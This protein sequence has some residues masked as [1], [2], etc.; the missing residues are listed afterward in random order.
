MSVCVC[1]RERETG[2]RTERQTDSACVRACSEAARCSPTIVSAVCMTDV[3]AVVDVSA[4]VAASTWLGHVYCS[5]RVT[6]VVVAG[7]NLS[8]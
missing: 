6:A 2:G 4:V 1:E 5:R 8:Q 7:S 3:F